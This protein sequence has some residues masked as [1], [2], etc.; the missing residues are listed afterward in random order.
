MEADFIG[1]MPINLAAKR[2]TRRMHIAELD[3]T[4]ILKELSARQFLQLAG[5]TDQVAVLAQMIVDEEGRRVFDSPEGMANLGE[6]GI[7]AFTELVA[8]ATELN[9]LAQKNVE[10]ITKNGSGGRNGD[11]ASGSP[12]T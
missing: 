5:T 10:D 4:I 1:R 3:M 9:G 7:H 12:V 11:S 2:K 6:L 8:A